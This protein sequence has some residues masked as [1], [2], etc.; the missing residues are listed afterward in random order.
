MTLRLNKI[1]K[2]PGTFNKRKRV[3]RGIGS[4]M[5]KTSCRGGKGQKARSGVSLNGFEGGQNPVYLRL[6]KRG[7]NPHAP[8]KKY[9]LTF[10]KI[11]D[12]LQ[13][14]T[15]RDSDLI[16]LD[17][18]RKLKI[19]SSSIDSLVLIKK[20]ELPGGL[21]IK[22]TVKKATKGALEYLESKGGVCTLVKD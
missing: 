2:N 8:S 13:K 5:G 18:L 17:Y 14:G 16:D 20:G 6:P 1:R 7:F 21:K 22:L 4:G 15:I 12:L 10:R 9:E 11:S 19:C 3:G